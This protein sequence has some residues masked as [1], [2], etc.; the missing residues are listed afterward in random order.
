MYPDN[1]HYTKEHEWVRVE[2]DIG[3]VGVTFHAQ[4]EEPCEEY[5]LILS[6]GRTLYNYNC[7]NMTRKAAVINQRDPGN[8]VEIHPDTAARY[9]ICRDEKIVVRT[10]RG[11]VT[12][13]AV[14]GDRVRP[15]IIWM[16]FHFAE[17]PTNNITNDVFDPVTATA[18]Y[19]CCAAQI[20][21]LVPETTATV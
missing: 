12:G 4:K 15:D 17:E 9:G 18:E 16:P 6:T 11:K 19:K 7:G 13:R 1:Y 5:P 14:V 21:K 3:T 8:F 20:G 10:R 2:G